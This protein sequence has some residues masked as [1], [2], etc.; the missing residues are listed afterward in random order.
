M[1][2]GLVRRGYSSAGGAETY[3]RGFAQAAIA[4]GHST[5]LFCSPGWQ[6]WDFG[7]KRII[8]NKAPLGFAVELAK[9][10]PRAHCDTLFSGERICFSDVYRA[11]D[12]VHAAWLQRRSAFV[13][14]LKKLSF[15]LNPKHLTLLVLE[16]ET[17]K[18]SRHII[19]NSQ[20]VK[21]EIDHFYGS[22][23]S[24][25]VHIVHNGIDPDKW[26]HQPG[27]RTETRQKL[28]LRENQRAIIF[29]GSGW[30]RKGLRFAIDAVRK[31]P[32][33]ILLVAGKDSRRGFEAPHVR[34]LDTTLPIPSLLQAS[35]AFILPTIY[36]PFSNATFEALAAGLPIITTTA[37]GCAEILNPQT[38][39]TAVSDP[40]DIPALS[41]ALE[42]WLGMP[43]SPFNIRLRQAHAAEWTLQR[44]FQET[45]H[46]ITS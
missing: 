15:R 27:L 24:A 12:G 11:G 31:V 4:A 46:I 17:M 18:R 43:L 42:H 41:Q 22:G 5:I 26:R 14:P 37:N 34:F 36:D 29:V 19:A 1:R 40:A 23:I 32:N 35:D 21:D 9:M 3:L 30:E 39:G 33:A 20:M 16:R 45:L 8:R 7:E 44:N 28:G 10:K 6:E 13:S 2:I 38:D 25:K